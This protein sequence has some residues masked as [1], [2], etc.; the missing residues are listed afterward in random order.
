MF[1]T[2]IHHFSSGGGYPGGFPGTNGHRTTKAPDWLADKW[3]AAA[4]IIA[5]QVARPFNPYP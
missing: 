2:N 4:K 5:G 1:P 3:V